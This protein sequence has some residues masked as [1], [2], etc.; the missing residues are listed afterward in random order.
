MILVVHLCN[1]PNYLIR[2]LAIL[3]A[4]SIFGVLFIQ[5]YWLKR[6]FNLQD[7]EFNQT[8]TIALLEVAQKIADFNESELPKQ[9]LIQRTSSNYYA[10]NINDNIDA[11]I[12]E[13]YLIREFGQRAINTD[14]EFAIYDCQSQELVYGSYCKMDNLEE[15]RDRSGVLPT[16]D[17][18]TYY[19][20]VKFPGQRGF[21]LSNMWQNIA[22]SFFTFLSLAFLVYAMWVILQQKRLSELQKDFINNMTHEFKTPIS[23]IKI[24]SDYLKKN[25]VL[26]QNPK[27]KKYTEII[28]DQNKRLNSQV[29]KVLSLAKLESDS[30]K[31]NLEPLQ[32]IDEINEIVDG[33]S[34]KISPGKIKVQQQGSV[35]NQTII[36]DRLHFTNV[37]YNI[38]D[39]AIK[40]CSTAPDILINIS[41]TKNKLV[42]NIEDN[43][44]GLKRDDLERV[45]QKFYRVSTGD[46]HDVKGFGLGL[47]YVKNI[48]KAHGW[49]ISIDSVF[50]EGSTFSIQIPQN[51]G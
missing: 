51:H 10:V 26:T 34:L 28:S 11:N 27:L 1:M 46:V 39:N 4:I 41:E 32:L 13:D 42:L 7:S 35:G 47:Y 2:R 36:G 43:G 29:E 16:F 3:G 15:S 50:G 20:V 24:A 25:E 31:L 22:F 17:N 33:E 19:F 18:L 48:C 5:A 45:F 37:I 44:V 21:L 8:V 38:I 12:L 14:F 40:Y 23:S 6:A 49:D 30:F 9:N